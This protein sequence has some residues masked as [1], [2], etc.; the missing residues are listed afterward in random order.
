MDLHLDKAQA[1]FSNHTS[2]HLILF[3]GRVFDFCAT[4]NFL[5]ILGS[6]LVQSQEAHLNA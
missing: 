2:L 6:L 1:L 5:V 4:K 3:S